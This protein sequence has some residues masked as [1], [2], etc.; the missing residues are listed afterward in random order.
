LTCY[1]SA[2]S[3]ILSQLERRGGRLHGRKTKARSKDNGYNI[4]KRPELVSGVSSKSP[5]RGGL[6]F[7]SLSRGTRSGHGGKTCNMRKTASS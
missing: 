3:Y 2:L 5:G 4:A 1:E 7:V 6:C